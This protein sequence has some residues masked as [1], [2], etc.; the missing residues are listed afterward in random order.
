MADG[1]GSCQQKFVLDLHDNFVCIDPAPDSL[2][3]TS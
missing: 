1:M 2:I 3:K